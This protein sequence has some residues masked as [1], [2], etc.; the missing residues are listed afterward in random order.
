MFINDKKEL[1]KNLSTFKN[2]SKSSLEGELEFYRGRVK[3][4]TCFIIYIDENELEFA[5]SRFIGYANN[6]I[7]SHKKNNKRDGR[8]TNKI[9]SNILGAKPRLIQNAEYAYINYCNTRK[10]ITKPFGTFNAPRKYW[11]FDSTVEKVLSE[12]YT[13]ADKEFI[14]KEEIKNSDSTSKKV[15]IDARKGQGEYRNELIDLWKSC[16]ITKCNIHKVL[17]ASHIKPWRY[18]NNQE[19]LDKYNGILLSP[20]YDT[21]FDLGLISFSEKGQLLV[22]KKLSSDNLKKLRI[23]SFAKINFCKYHYSY[24]KFHRENIFDK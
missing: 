13:N 22:S 11:L 23:D 24:L 16:P 21:L 19:R 14:D 18:S 1:I 7:K 3:R 4:G 17:K 15:L 20:I 5:P 10:I 2:Y 6:N 9:I 8:I 12:K